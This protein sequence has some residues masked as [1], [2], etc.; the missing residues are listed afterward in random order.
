MA[1]V[2]ISDHYHTEH[3]QNILMSLRIIIIKDLNI[4]NISHKKK[5]IIKNFRCF[6][7]SLRRL[8][9]FRVVEGACAKKNV[10]NIKRIKPV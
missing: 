3:L 10:P 4:A 6:Q 7:I 5:I 9:K 1:T 2:A 8:T